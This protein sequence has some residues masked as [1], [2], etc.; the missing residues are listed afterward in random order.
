MRPL[1]AGTTLTL[2]TA[3]TLSC[4]RDQRRPFNVRLTA[5][6][7]STVKVIWSIPAAETPDGYEVWFRPAGETAFVLVGETSLNLFVHD[8]QGR[9]GDYRVSARYGDE[10]HVAVTEPSTIPVTT[11]TIVL[12]ELNSSGNSGLGWDRTTGRARS[13]P[14]NR[15][16]SAAAVDL[17][18]TDFHAGRVPQ[19]PYSI[20]SPD[21]APADPG[22]G[23]SSADWRSTE[24]TDPMALDTAA[25]PPYSSLYWFNYSDL[26]RIPCAIGCRTH[27]GYYARIEACA[28]TAPEGWLK[29]ICRFQRVQGLRLVPH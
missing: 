15:S 19:P 16:G 14:M 11:D 17:Y 7:D 21:M 20:A 26:V 29:V 1:V 3:L 18:I 4:G 6:S 24:F 9:T 23:V 12:A 28:I 22:G 2:L 27:D 25:L 5:A 8:P 10:R 13:L